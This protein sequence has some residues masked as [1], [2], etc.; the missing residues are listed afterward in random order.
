MRVRFIYVALLISHY[1]LAAQIPVKITGWVTNKKTDEPLSYASVLIQNSG[2]GTITNEAGEF[3][4][5]LPA[6]IKADT[7]SIS[8]IGFKTL[9]RSISD[10]QGATNFSLQEASIILNEIAIDNNSA[11]RLLESAL[12]AIPAVCPTTPYLLEGFHRSWEKV[13]FSDSLRCPGTLIEAAVTIYGPASGEGKPGEKSSEE[14]YINEIRRTALM[15]NWNYGQSSLSDLIDKNI[16]AH[17]KANIFLSLK[18]FLDFPN[19]MIYEWDEG[20]EIDGESLSV[21]HVDVPNAKNFPVYFKIYVSEEDH[22]ILRF[23][24]LG[25]KSIIDYTVGPWHTERIQITYIFKRYQQKLY[26]HYCKKQYT[27]KYLDLR[28]RCVLRTEDYYRDLLISNI[29]IS[30][31]QSKRASLSMSK[32]KKTSLALQANK[33]NEEFWK[34]Y[35]VIIENPLDREIAAFFE[36]AQEQNS[37]CR[38]IKKDRGN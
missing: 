20:T 13:T 16:V 22:A 27:I 31:V 38:Q 6:D 11:K 29:L 10:L 4:L 25:E 8:H 36:G 28:K 2:I 19:D 15:E 23:D 9:N 3:E 37:P 26:L 35:N 17:P 18:S 21:I 32:S 14:I 33:Y 12:Q 7:I 1:S 24:L 34:Y 30:D 5:V